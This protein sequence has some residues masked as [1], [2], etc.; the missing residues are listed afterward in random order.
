MYYRWYNSVIW[1]VYVSLLPCM[2]NVYV[3]PDV[4]HQNDMNS[5]LL[6]R[7]NLQKLGP[8]KEVPDVTCRFQEMTM[9]PVVFF[10]NFHVDFK[11]AKCHL[12]N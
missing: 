3:P 11:I 2:D 7:L 8:L 10:F 12:S 4:Y 5:R 9:S 1:C 6:Y